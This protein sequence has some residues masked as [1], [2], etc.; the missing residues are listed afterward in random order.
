MQI[1]SSVK[2]IIFDLGEVILNIDYSLCERAFERL[3][4][5][6]FKSIYSQKEQI[7]LFDD[8]ETGKISDGEFRRQLMK[9]IPHKISPKQFDDAWNAMLLDLPNERIR[10][11]EKLKNQYRTFLLSNTNE[12][13]IR[14]LSHYLKQTF[15]FEDFSHLFEK[16]YLSYKIGM[17]KPEPQ[18]FNYV[19]REN[20]I[21]KE[22]T[23]FI[24]DSIQHIEAAKKIG[25][26]TLLIEKGRTIL[27]YFT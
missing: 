23:L 7:G 13:H 1:D 19:L 6:N 24:D 14:W 15:G 20:G 27:D 3:G 10:L 11:L 9:L 22:E 4:I 5:K 16:V 25:I 8:F 21:R 26:R 2:N 12:I 17:R 18:T